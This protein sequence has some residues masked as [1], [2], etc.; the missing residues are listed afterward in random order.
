MSDPILRIEQVFIDGIKIQTKGIVKKICKL[1]GKL[2]KR[3]APSTESRI[4]CPAKRQDGMD[5]A[6]LLDIKTT[7]GDRESEKREHN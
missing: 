7:F 3:F 4:S 5:F 6:S 2:K 1:L